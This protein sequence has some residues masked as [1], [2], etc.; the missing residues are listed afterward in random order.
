MFEGVRVGH[1]AIKEK[2]KNNKSK[3]RNKN[4]IQRS[5]KVGLFFDNQ[6]FLSDLLELA[7]RNTNYHR[8]HKFKM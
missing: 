4:T 3:I 7:V 1:G 5:L 2:E 6:L 8:E